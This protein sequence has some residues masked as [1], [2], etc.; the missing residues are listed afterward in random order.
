MSSDTVNSKQVKGHAAM[1]PTP[2]VGALGTKYACYLQLCLG[3]AI[4]FV[5]GRLFRL[6]CH[7]IV[8]LTICF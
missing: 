3:G 6:L 7:D 1:P 4:R 2:T 8:L 5:A